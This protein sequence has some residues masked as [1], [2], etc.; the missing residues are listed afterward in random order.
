M[1][2]DCVQLRQAGLGPF[3]SQATCFGVKLHGSVDAS[4]VLVAKTTQHV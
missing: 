4:S 3:S 2:S 1:R